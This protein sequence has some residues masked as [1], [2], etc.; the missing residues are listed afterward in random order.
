MPSPEVYEQEYDFW[1][2]GKVLAEATKVA[3]R[4]AERSSFILDYMCGTGLLLTKILSKR[5][6]LSALGCDIS[7]PYINYARTT[8]AAAK[9]ACADARSYRPERHP[10]FVIC[11]AG[12]HHLSRVDQPRFIEKVSDELRP[13]GLFLLGEEVIRDYR[14]ESDRKRAVL[15]MFS[16][17]MNFLG[18]RKPPASVVQA[19][20]DMLSNDWCERGEYKTTCKELERMLR[21]SF[22]IISAQ[23]IWPGN[24]DAFGD[25]LFLCRKR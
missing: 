7:K 24:I 5:S 11:T 22:E 10:D 3:V 9:F 25:W 8:Y 23:Q 20:T 2:W 12:L 13:G 6:D 14:S 15:E 16:E 1:P 21:P 17:L 4:H 18:R 19:A